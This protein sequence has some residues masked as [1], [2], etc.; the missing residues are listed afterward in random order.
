MS[1]NV[2]NVNENEQERT[3]EEQLEVQAVNA[4]RDRKEHGTNDLSQLLA[5]WEGQTDSSVESKVHLVVRIANL[6]AKAGRMSDC[7][8]QYEN[9]I[10][11]AFYEGNDD[12]V[13]LLIKERDVWFPP[14]S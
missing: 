1:E 2:P 8:E 5:I 7:I 11:I 9:A 3:I 10:D 12:L 14:K 13:H 4:L 6:Y